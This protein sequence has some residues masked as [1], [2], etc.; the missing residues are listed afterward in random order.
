MR[1][2]SRWVG[3]GVRCG[4]QRAVWP[5]SSERAR[6]RIRGEGQGERARARGEGKTTTVRGANPHSEGVSRSDALESREL[7]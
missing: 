3:M 1:G 5:V 2:A 6:V 4:G 7:H